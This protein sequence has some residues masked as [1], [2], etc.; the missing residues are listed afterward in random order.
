LSNPLG[1][2][3]NGGLNPT[4]PLSYSFSDGATNLTGANSA[5]FAFQIFTGSTGTINAWNIVLYSPN[6][7]SPVIDLG[8]LSDPSIPVSLDASIVFGGAQA[9]NSGVP[10][11]WTVTSP[12]PARTP[13][14]SSLILLGSGL[15]GVLGAARRKL[16]V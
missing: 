7:S 11:T 6:L 4:I 9:F 14:P 12:P 15:L 8:T 1:A 13:E 10:G 16:R 3:L 2:N 5:P